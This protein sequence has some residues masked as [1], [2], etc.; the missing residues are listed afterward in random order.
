VVTD[1]LL[2]STGFSFHNRITKQHHVCT[3]GI[4]L[5]FWLVAM[6]AEP[7]ENAYIGANGLV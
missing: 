2:V 4:F 3:F 6:C 7:V 1:W 5:F